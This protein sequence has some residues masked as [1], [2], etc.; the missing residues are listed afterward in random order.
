MCKKYLVTKSIIE[1]KI[2]AKFK[3]INELVV[4]DTDGGCGQSF[5]VKIK[6]PEFKGKSLIEQHRIINEILKDEV[7]QIHSLVLKTSGS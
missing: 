4:Q 2:K 5:M 1:G 6:T 3:I 7:N